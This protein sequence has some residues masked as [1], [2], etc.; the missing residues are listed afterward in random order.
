ML[1]HKKA[2]GYSDGSRLSPI[3]NKDIYSAL[4]SV[5]RLPCILIGNTTVTSIDT[6]AEICKAV[7]VDVAEPQFIEASETLFDWLYIR[8][9]WTGWQNGKWYILLM[10][11]GHIRGQKIL[12]LLINTILISDPV[13][14]WFIHTLDNWKSSTGWTFGHESEAIIIK[15]NIA[16]NIVYQGTLYYY[17]VVLNTCCIFK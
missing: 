8:R 9:L 11:F 7:V 10:K 2:V 15:G 5:C 13:Y 3:H 6:V 17:F 4:I 16:I 14:L 1:C 12:I